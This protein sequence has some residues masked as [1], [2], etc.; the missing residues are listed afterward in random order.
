MLAEDHKQ[1]SWFLSSLRLTFRR[2]AAAPNNMILRKKV[3]NGE[4]FHL[5][6]DL[7]DWIGLIIS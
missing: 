4:I 6:A 5:R 1:K 2:S 3:E 7:D